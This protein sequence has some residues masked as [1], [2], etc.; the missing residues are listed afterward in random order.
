MPKTKSKKSRSTADLIVGH[1]EKHLA[2]KPHLRLFQKLAARVDTVIFALAGVVVMLAAFH[3]VN[4]ADVESPAF[5][6]Q[7]ATDYA[8]QQAFYTGEEREVMH[9]AAGEFADARAKIREAAIA[10][11][12]SRALNYVGLFLILGGLWY[13]HDRHDVFRINRA[14]FTIRKIR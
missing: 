13:L 5:V 2:R 14:G 12:L 1:A 9:A 4:Y 10:A 6:A 8:A 11:E 7:N 3:I